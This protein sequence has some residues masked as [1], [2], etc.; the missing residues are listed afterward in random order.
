MAETFGVRLQERLRELGPLCVG[1]DPSSEVLTRWGRPDSVEGLEFCALAVLEAVTGVAAVIK[2]QVA[3]FERFGSAGFR[4]L[5]RLIQEAHDAE[6]LVVAD[7]KRGDVDSTNEGYAQ[8]WL[9]DGSPLAVDAVTV[10][11]YLGVAALRPLF[12][13]AAASGR[14]VF[15][16]AATSNPEGRS[17][18]EARTFEQ[19]R[20]QEM[21]LRAIAELNHRD[22]GLGS[23]GVVLG[24]TRDAPA[25]DLATL[26]GPYLVPGIGAQGA[27][28][29]DVARL[30]ERCEQGTVLVNVARAVL[31]AGPERRGLLDAARR[32]RDDLLDA[33]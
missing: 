21:V 6:L 18:Q 11:P 27:G 12:D 4:V 9:R 19:E 29:K 28:V 8:A 3:F 17:L 23:F 25:F 30:F 26:G 2:P 20:V 10:H 15:V 14:G 32:W 22:D 33:L 1:V 7:A 24:A 31:F 16:V 13:A 5:E